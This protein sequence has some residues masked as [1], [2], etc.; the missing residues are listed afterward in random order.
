LSWR[1]TRTTQMVTQYRWLYRRTSPLTW[2]QRTPE[3][4]GHRREQ[5]LP[6]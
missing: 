5:G 6:T 4:P 2:R 3:S 1:L